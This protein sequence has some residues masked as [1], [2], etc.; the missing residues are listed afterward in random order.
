MRKAQKDIFV[1]GNFEL[2]D[3]GHSD[4]FAYTRAFGGQ[5]ALV[6]CN[7][8]KEL[9][10][11]PLPEGFKV[12]RDKVLTSNYSGVSGEEG[13]RLGLRPFEGFACLLT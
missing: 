9:V 8:R 4:V 2:V 6:V 13:G 5:K 10:S 7:F 12:E 3:A 11:W 1:Y